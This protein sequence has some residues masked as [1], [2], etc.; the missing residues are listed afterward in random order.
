MQETQQSDIAA[1]SSGDI[2]QPEPSSGFDV[3]ELFSRGTAAPANAEESA[4]EAVDAPAGDATA[5][6]PTPGDA[7]DDDPEVD[8]QDTDTAGAEPVPQEQRVF[9]Y[10]AVVAQNPNRLS[11]V[12][13]KL[14]PEVVKALLSAAYVR[15]Q[16][17]SQAQFQRQS[18]TE[19]Q[20][21]SFVS[22]RDEFARTSP[23]EFRQW[24]D[25][26]P[27]EAA[28]YWAAKANF[29]QKAAPPPDAQQPLAPAVIQE[30]ANVKLARVAQLP[31]AQRNSFAA[32]VN[33]GEFPL[34]EVG[35]DALETALF[36]AFTEA[37]RSAPAGA[38]PANA[39]TRMRTEQRQRAAQT[40][41]AA[42][43]AVGLA[44]GGV[45]AQPESYDPDELF[46]AAATQSARR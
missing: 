41:A 6:E 1:T 25:E 4:P 40:R 29:A 33:A 24:Q 5:D 10:A 35:L 19:E 18:Q 2:A 34:T 38:A 31:E 13:S 16:Q 39:E 37:A 21:R 7:V 42:P 17:E 26:N 9:D 14:R 15:G 30:R 3:D 12:P 11:E 43:K 36:D 32:R 45:N 46:A 22:D 28:R 27:V 23:D 20:A 8:D 44:G